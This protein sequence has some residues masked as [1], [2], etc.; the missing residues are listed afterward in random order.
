MKPKR[1]VIYLLLALMVP[2][3]SGCWYAVAAGAGAT[4]GYVMRDKGY[5]VQSPVEKE[6]EK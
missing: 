2:A 4:A 6:A 5:K 1:L 3:L